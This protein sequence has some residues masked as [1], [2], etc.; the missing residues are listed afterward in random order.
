MYG[1]FA[2]I[3]LLQA[4]CIYH[5]Y[6]KNA[7]QRWF[8]LIALFPLIGS[9]IYLIQNFNNR[10]TLDALKENV[11]VV[12]NSNYRLDQLEK[13]LRFSDNITNKLNLADAY[14]EAGRHQE[15]IALYAEC[16]Q[17]FMADDPAIRMKLLKARYLN[18]D[19]GAVVECGDKLES[20]RSFKDSDA[21][22][23]YAWSLFHEGNVAR[24]ENVFNQMDIAFTNYYHRMEFCKFLLK[25]DR[26]DA[27]KENLTNLMKEFDQM[28]SG[29]RRL[30][31]HVLSE[32]KEVYAVNFSRA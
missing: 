3:L 17:G 19:Y 22:V 18:G 21:R 24:A 16:L 11:K 27:A 26:S 12:V 7:E 8:W 6:R 32:V 29:E 28:Q 13:A 2:P 31:R 25:T 23:A 15:A 5:A 9:V 14:T 10:T 1:F 20:E 30:M 4:F